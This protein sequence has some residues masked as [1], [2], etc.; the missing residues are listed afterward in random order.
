MSLIE[1][2]NDDMKQSMKNQEK[3]KLNVIR[4]L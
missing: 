4:L 3:E 2:I 1:K